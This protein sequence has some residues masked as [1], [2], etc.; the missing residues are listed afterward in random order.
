MG[1]IIH[2]GPSKFD[3]RP[4]IVVALPTSTN[5]KT[6]NMLQTYI[7]RADLDPIT[8]NKFGE[9]E[10]IC[11]TCSLRGTPTLDPT[12][13][14]AEDRTCYVTLYQ[15]P[16]SVFKAY[17]RGNY[18][19]ALTPRQIQNV[20]RGKRVRIGTYG[21][22]AAVPERVW[23]NLLMYADGHTA[24]THGHAD[25]GRFMY[26][27]ETHQQAQRAWHD[28]RRTFR[29]VSAAEQIDARNEVQCPSETHGVQCVDCMLCSG[30]N[31]P[32]KSVAI[33]VHGAG[34]R[35]FKEI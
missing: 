30:A 32:G 34:A 31:K 7:L 28:G 5:D 19:R 35:N 17:T 18:Q 27:V 9:D 24:Y 14:T 20:G 12:R 22:G 23:D 25:P 15:G 2:E 13:K 33:V 8:A 10:S 11:G 1:Y 26:S 16:L 29:I 3:G 4:I 6:G 21:D